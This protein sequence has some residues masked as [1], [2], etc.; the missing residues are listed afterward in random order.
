MGL[1][2]ALNRERETTLVLVTHDTGIA[3][4]RER[5]ITIEAEKTRGWVS[6]MA[7]KKG[8]QRAGLL[9]RAAWT[10]PPARR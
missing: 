1:M 2:F 7:K 10:T 8:V 3:Q 6:L 9:A 5:Q 4:M